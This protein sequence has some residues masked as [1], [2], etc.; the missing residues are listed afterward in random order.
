M[1]Q[2]L[3]SY[4]RDQDKFSMFFLQ[5]FRLAQARNFVEITEKFSDPEL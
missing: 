2:Y 3:G 4:F 1:A 5:F